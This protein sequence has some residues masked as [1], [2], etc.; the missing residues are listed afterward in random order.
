VSGAAPQ[1]GFGGTREGIRFDH[2]QAQLTRARS[3][4]LA[5]AAITEPEGVTKPAAAGA[6]TDRLWADILTSVPG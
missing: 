6:F 1:G 5:I 4:S 3:I 2:W